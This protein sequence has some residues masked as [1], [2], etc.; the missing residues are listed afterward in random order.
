MSAPASPEPAPAA[1]P[2]LA[3]SLGAAATPAT[4]PSSDPAPVVPAPAP[5]GNTVADLAPATPVNQEKPAVPAPPAES[6]P[7]APVPPTPA[8]EKSSAAQAFSNP[9][10]Q[11]QCESLNS[12]DLRVVIKSLKL[13]RQLNSPEAVPQVLL[14][15]QH[16]NYKVVREACHTLSVL[17]DRS[18][19]P[20]LQSLLAR[21]D[22]KAAAHA[23]IVHLTRTHR[24]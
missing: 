18:T 22:V 23:A 8:P 17:G 3:V 5:A 15:L 2:S 21:R 10:V 13:L 6:V 12:P 9:A 20:A 7:P 1:N 16:P 14:C 24:R 4:A 19:I 11:R